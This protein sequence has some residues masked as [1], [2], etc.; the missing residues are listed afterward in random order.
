ML[1][2]SLALLFLVYSAGLIRLWRH[3]GVGAGVRPWE[4]TAFAGGFLAL[5]V[6]LL[7]PI[8][9]LADKWLVAHMVQHELLMAVAAPL[10]AVSGVTFTTLS[11]LPAAARDRR[12]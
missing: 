11:A 10:M 3:A 9:G 12:L 4:A 6:A 2:S 8:D 5:A 1:A 7:P